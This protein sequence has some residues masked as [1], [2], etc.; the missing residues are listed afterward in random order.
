[1][2]SVVIVSR[3]DGYGENLLER[4]TLCL[5]YMTKTFDEVIYVD[6]NSE[7]ISLIEQIK[8]NLT[9]RDN[10]KEIIVTP[11]QHKKLIDGKRTLDIVEVYGRN[12]GIR[13]ASGDI[14]VCTNIDIIPPTTNILDNFIKYNFDK[15]TFYT[16]SR[17]NVKI[18][19]DL[20][21]YEDNENLRTTLLM[22]NRLMVPKGNANGIVKHARIMCC[23]DFQ[24]AHKDVWNA[25]K[26]FEESFYLRGM[27]DTQIQMKAEITG[28]PVLGLYDLPLFH[29]EHGYGDRLD[30]KTLYNPNIYPE[31]PSTNEDTWGFTNEKFII[32][33]R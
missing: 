3:N 7:G 22:N 1:M 5:N 16:F 9:P 19:V 21:N 20:N 15:N 11:E 32:K 26:G 23:G 17:K 12:I 30:D 24:M 10:L 25:I 8:V 28:Y 29:I 6:Y 14:I 13:H 33:Q 4:A 31:V 2:K 18:E 27:A